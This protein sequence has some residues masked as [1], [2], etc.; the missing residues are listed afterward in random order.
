VKSIPFSGRLVD[1][2]ITRLAVIAVAR[3]IVVDVAVGT[4]IR[5]A[6]K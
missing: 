4:C 2:R 6:E 3:G 5:T 1:G